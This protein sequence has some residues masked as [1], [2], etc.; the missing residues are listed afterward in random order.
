MPN[1]IDLR[2]RV[3]TAWDDTPTGQPDLPAIRRRGSRRRVSRG[4]GGVA[5]TLCIA[6]GVGLPLW[7][8]SG[9]QG[10]SPDRVADGQQGSSPSASQPSPTD[11]PGVVP[12]SED[13]EVIA[14][15]IAGYVV[16]YRSASGGG[17]V[18]QADSSDPLGTCEESLRREGVESSGHWVM[19][20]TPGYVHIA[21][22]EDAAVC[23]GL[24]P[25][26]E[27]P[28]GY[29]AA[30]ERINAARSSLQLRY[31]QKG[32]LCFRHHAMVRLTE[33]TL[34]SEGLRRWSVVDRWDPAG[35]AC[36]WPSYW[37][38]EQFQVHVLNEP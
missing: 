12:V 14:E 23:D 17:N 31:P 22:V 35:T 4:L 2:Q 13:G 8:L 19:C 3:R 38:F 5:A 15:S 9:V 28:G 6:A 10:G 16:C 29:E 1:D 21:R 25:L 36:A 30:V 18:L 27:L 26:S 34:A 7:Q 20:A 24:L 33:E 37:D 32:E 11:S